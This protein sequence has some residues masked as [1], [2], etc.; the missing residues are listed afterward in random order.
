LKS[1]FPQPFVNFKVHHPHTRENWLVDLAYPQ[2][3]IAIEYQ[4]AEFHTSKESLCKDS[5]KISALQGLGW[6]VIPVTSDD[7]FIQE[8]WD[9]FVDTLRAV[10]S[11]KTN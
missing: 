5:R 7:V 4:G 1:R 10:I 8:H 2:L 3:K 11:S 6:S 9:R